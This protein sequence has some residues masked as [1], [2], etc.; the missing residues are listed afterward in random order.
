MEVRE[1][2]RNTYHRVCPFQQV[3]CIKDQCVFWTVHDTGYTCE[4]D[5]RGIEIPNT[6]EYHTTYYCKLLIKDVK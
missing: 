5:W 3:P 1:Y 2:P 4:Y 6:R